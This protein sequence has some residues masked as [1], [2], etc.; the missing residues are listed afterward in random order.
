MVVDILLA[1]LG[2]VAVFLVPGMLW[3]RV[4]LRENGLEAWEMI[5][6]SFVVGVV[7][8]SL[9]IFFTSFLLAVPVNALTLS[10]ILLALSAFPFSVLIYR[11]DPT[12]VKIARGLV[13]RIGLRS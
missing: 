7:I 5:A 6:I 1:I 13:A 9:T 10:L 3:T 4:F 8:V 12:L 11:K 2:Y